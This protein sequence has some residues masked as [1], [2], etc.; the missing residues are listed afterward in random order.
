MRAP[1][2]C[3]VLVAGEYYCDLVFAGL[4]DTPRLG[5]EVYAEG[6]TV[7]TGGTYTMA[8]A[9][10]RLGVSTRWAADFGTDLFSRYVLD[11]AAEDGIDPAGFRIEQKPL[12]R[13]T[14][15]F[16]AS[17]ER[18]FISYA[19]PALVPAP[20][21]G[22]PQWLL[23]TFRFEPDWLAFIAETKRAGARI[24]ADCRS[25]DFTLA[26]PG[27]RDFLALV[28]VFSPNAAE[29]KALAETEDLDRAIAVLAPLVPILVVKC[30]SDGALLVKDGETIHCP[31]PRVTAVDT[32]GAGDAFNAGFLFAAAGGLPLDAALEAG[33]LAGSFSV[34]GTGG[35]ACPS[36]AELAQFALGHGRKLHHCLVA[37]LT[38]AAIGQGEPI[39]RRGT[40]P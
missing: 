32:I 13:V 7:M 39:T 25:G 22:R 3:D 33:V 16:S 14:A 28:D 18:G 17:G 24:F 19:D 4:E 2:D 1:R 23:Q 38:G 5:A 21:V 34:Q 27:V 8:L 30:G 37:L 15:A 26:T 35:R 9:L 36:R 40:R 20:S 29:A 10:T 31:A 6:L 11:C 12:P